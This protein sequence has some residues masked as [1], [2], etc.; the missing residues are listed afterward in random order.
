MAVSCY[1]IVFIATLTVLVTSISAKE[2][3][4]GDA[5]GWS[6]DYDYQIWAK[7]KVF[8]VGDTLVFNY[9][10]GAHNVVK[11]NATDFQKCTTS[12]SNGILTSGSDVITLLT[13]GVKWYICGVGKHCEVKKMK[14]VITVLPQNL[15]VAP[16]PTATSASIKSTVP[17]IYGFLATLFGSLL[18]I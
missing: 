4:V 7:D 11:V 1:T 8:F 16:S 17:L 2:Y 14:L 13:P 9:P 3:I 15:A 5:N 18:L 10:P 6:L 12:S